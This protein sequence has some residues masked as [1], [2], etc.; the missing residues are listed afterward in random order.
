[1]HF[2]SSIRNRKLRFATIHHQLQSSGTFL[3]HISHCE[4]LEK[5]EVEEDKA[6]GLPRTLPETFLH[7]YF[8]FGGGSHSLI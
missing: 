6:N 2:C 5:K 8:F 3:L 7:I 4:H 1:M